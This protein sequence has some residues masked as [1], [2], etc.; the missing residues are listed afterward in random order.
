MFD[1]KPFWHAF[2][3]PH[4]AL[5]RLGDAGAETE[6]PFGGQGDIGQTGHGAA[7]VCQNF[8]DLAF[9]LRVGVEHLYLPAIKRKARGPSAAD[10]TTADDCCDFGHCRIL[11]WSVS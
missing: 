2:L 8:G 9:G 11:S 6:P 5:H 10:Y 1:L 7:G 4:G 3:Y